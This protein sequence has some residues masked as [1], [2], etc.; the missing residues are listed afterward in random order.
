MPIEWYTMEWQHQ[1]Q[2]E[3]SLP[4]KEKAT[5]IQRE[6]VLGGDICV[7]AAINFMECG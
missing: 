1:L 4:K 6:E 5:L 2:P 3:V 7:L